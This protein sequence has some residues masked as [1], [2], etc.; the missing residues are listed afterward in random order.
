[1][2]GLAINEK[3]AKRGKWPFL[4]ALYNLEAH[5]FLC[6]GNIITS[7]PS[8]STFCPVRMRSVKYML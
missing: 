8:R 3:V 5:Q 6:G 4:A 1:M 7:Q 2:Q